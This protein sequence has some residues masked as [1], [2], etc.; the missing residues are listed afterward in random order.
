M[1]ETRHVHG[2][3]LGLLPADLN[4]PVI[5]FAAVRTGAVPT[6]PVFADHYTGA[7]YGLYG[8]DRHS[9]C[10]PTMIANMRRAITAILGGREVDPTQADVD[11]LYSRSTNPPYDPRTGANDNGVVLADLLS[12]CVKGGIGGVKALAYAA[13]DVK[14]LDEVKAAISI[15]GALALGVELDTAQQAQTDAG[16]WDYKRSGLWGGH[17]VPVLG[18]AG[19]PTGRDFVIVSWKDLIGMT[20]SFWQH[21]VQEAYA[22]AWPEHTGTR[23]FQQ[24]IDVAAWNAAYTALTGRPGPLPTS[25]VTPTPVT[26]TPVTPGPVAPPADARTAADADLMKAFDTWRATR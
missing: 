19:A 17:A 26:P 10:G 1:T 22:V 13:I 6:H 24:G 7:T 8:N 12:A 5:R 25:P 23:Q 16:L 3:R 2:R 21:Q 15:F 14:N 9:D 20:D 4:R 11:D 18:Y